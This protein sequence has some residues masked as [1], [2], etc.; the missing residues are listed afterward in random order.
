MKKTILFFLILTTIKLSA[1]NNIESIVSFTFKIAPKFDKTEKEVIKIDSNKKFSISIDSSLLGDSIK[2]IAS[3]IVE[4]RSSKAI[5]KWPL[6][7]VLEENDE[8]LLEFEIERIDKTK[9]S[10]ATPIKAIQ[11][12]VIKRVD[13]PKEKTADEKIK[14][15]I[16]NSIKEAFEE[17]TK[18][19]GIGQFEF[20]NKYISGYKMPYQKN[21]SRL[22]KKKK[23]IL[24]KD[25][26][27]K[28]QVD[29][30]YVRIEDGVIARRGLFVKA[31]DTNT[32]KIFYFRNMSAPISL[33]NN[34]NKYN[35]VL[36][37]H[38]DSTAENIAIKYGDILKYI[39]KGKFGY[40]DNAEYSVTPERKVATVS[41]KVTLKDIINVSIF[42]DLLSL[43][44]RRAN[45]IIQTEI[46]AQ[47]ITNTSNRRNKDY[48]GFSYV[49]PY[50]SFSKFDSKFQQ[51]DTVN[52]SIKR[53]NGK[54]SINRL[55]INQIAY[56][57]AGV[58]LNIFRRS[59]WPNEQLQ[60][61]IG[62]EMTLTN[63]DSI[64][65]KDI[66]LLNYYPEFL[67][68]VTRM[69]NFGME[70]SMKCLV[71]V[72]T[73]NLDFFNHKP[74]Y[75]FNPQV[76]L[77]YYPFSN[78]DN[79]LYFKYAYFSEIASKGAKSSFAQL[80]FGYKTNLFKASK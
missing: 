69:E 66:V 62:A 10:A 64:Y 26:V 48:T 18:E 30:I 35:D 56:I 7:D 12:L 21:I 20:Q 75:I 25:T 54:D 79:R 44:G 78:P 17:E 60:F 27:H 1:Q 49:A 71:Q 42:S 31:I 40:P 9:G 53:I 28:L 23:I 58:K 51:I 80:Q 43:L 52:A 46:T 38:N 72:P 45:G 70:A 76:T 13:Q 68:K 39:F 61:N 33:A 36:S 41:N 3:K 59:Y 4:K 22:T 73:K 14:E 32:K 5:E 29:S 67:Y 19:K 11:K 50:F 6:I 63:A 16:R 65:K 24:I 37:L 57:R 55:Y 74:V 15:T 47:F 77:Y 34:E 2:L 8:L